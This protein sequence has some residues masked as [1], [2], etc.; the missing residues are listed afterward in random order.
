MRDAYSN[1]DK[2]FKINI[3]DSRSASHPYH[4]KEYYIVKKGDTLS[5]IAVEHQTTVTL[6]CKLNKI[7]KTD[8]LRV[9]RRIRIR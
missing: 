7:K 5:K 6:L 8:K 9:G 1:L 2:T 4:E 3:V